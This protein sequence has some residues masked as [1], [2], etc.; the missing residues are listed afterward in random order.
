MNFTF[1]N[2]TGFTLM[3][4]KPKLL[5]VLVAALGLLGEGCSTGAPAA[6]KPKRKHAFLPVTGSHIGRRV[7]VKEDGTAAGPPA[8]GIQ[9]VNPGVLPELQRKG[10][11]NRGPR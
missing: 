11:V 8:D 10:S 4:T 2:V 9:T 5:I 6:A 7:A 3:T 1:P